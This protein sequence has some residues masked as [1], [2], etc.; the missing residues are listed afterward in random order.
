MRAGQVMLVNVDPRLTLACQ[1]VNKILSLNSNKILDSF[2]VGGDEYC[3]GNGVC[4]CG[5][6]QCKPGATG[7]FCE[8]CEVTGFLVYSC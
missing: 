4:E 6:C 2:F 5:S 7:K 3:L 8:D 1:W